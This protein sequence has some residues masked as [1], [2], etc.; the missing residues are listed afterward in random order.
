MTSLLKK[1]LISIKIGVIKLS[2]AMESVWSVSKLSTESV[3]SRREQNIFVAS[4]SAVCIGHFRRPQF[5]LLRYILAHNVT[6][7][8]KLPFCLKRVLGLRYKSN[9]FRQEQLWSGV[10]GWFGGWLVCSL[11]SL[12]FPENYKSD[13]NAVWHTYSTSA[14]NVTTNFWEVKVKVRG[15][16]AVLKIFQSYNNSVAV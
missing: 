4:A 13:F 1:L 12:W 2:N 16:I 14:P 3:G 5:P 15:Q 7:A 10:V 9:Y 11:R 8:S 6:L